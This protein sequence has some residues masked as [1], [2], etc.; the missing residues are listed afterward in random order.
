MSE[1]NILKDADYSRNETW[2]DSIRR[3][4]R[5]LRLTPA[6]AAPTPGPD[7]SDIEAEADE[8]YER[9]TAKYAPTVSPEPER[10]VSITTALKAIRCES[11]GKNDIAYLDEFLEGVRARLTAPPVKPDPAVEAA[12]H[13]VLQG[14]SRLLPS[15]AKEIVAAVRNADALEGK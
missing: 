12:Q 5:S 6:P 2:T 13:V 14:G 15:E 10:M 8:A 1:L 9:A 11:A 3:I 4:L 7:Y